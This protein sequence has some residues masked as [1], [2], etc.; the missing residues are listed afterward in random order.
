MTMKDTVELPPPL[1][2]G[3]DQPTVV[4]DVLYAFPG[5]LDKLLPEW[6]AIPEE[7]KTNGRENPWVHFTNV[8]FGFGWPEKSELYVRPDVEPE[9]AFR[10]MHT[11]LRSFEPK[12][13]HKIAGVAWLMSRW[14]A[15]IRPRG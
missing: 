3:F 1:N 12:H 5:H 9:T 11:I 10:H 7:F 14:Y 8:W 13:E 15:A 4:D 6:D 2:D